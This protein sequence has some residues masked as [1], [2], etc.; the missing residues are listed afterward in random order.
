[1]VLV[2]VF[3]M[4]SFSPLPDDGPTPKEEL[5]CLNKR[6]SVVVHIVKDSLGEA[7]VTEADINGELAGVN[8]KFDE[9]CVSFEV[10]EFRYIDNFQWDT[11]DAVGGVEWNQMLTAH[12]EAYRINIFYVNHIIDPPGVAGFA[13]LFGIN[14]TQGGGICIVKP[15][16]ALLHEM[17]HYWGLYHPFETSNGIELVDGSNCET[18][19]D[20]VCDTPADPYVQFNPSSQYETDCIFDAELQDVNGD[21]Y[22]PDVGNIMS[23]YDCSCHFTYDQYVRM[24]N[25][26]TNN[27]QPNGQ[28]NW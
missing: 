18:A 4:V 28:H 2:A 26:Y 13:T 6:F 10:C 19:G 24:A 5:P 25:T 9:I 14:N 12:H 11:L 1:M 27:L 20:L 7:N 21:W 15:G 8:D 3:S 17:G 22:D 16:G 23:Y